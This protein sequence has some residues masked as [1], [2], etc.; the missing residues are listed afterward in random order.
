[1]ASQERSVAPLIKGKFW[2][3]GKVHDL[4][5][6]TAW[7]HRIGALLTNT[8]ILESAAFA[9]AIRPRQTTER[10][11]GHPL[12]IHWPM[13]LLMQFEE[14][15]EVHI[16]NVVCPLAE[17]DLILTTTNARAQ[18]SLAWEVEIT[19]HRPRF[20]FEETKPYIRRSMGPFA[21]TTAIRVRCPWPTISPT[22]RLRST[23][24]MAHS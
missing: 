18:F 7:C 10:P 12:V 1:M 23:S 16:G 21:S 2:S 19:G 5:D 17:C 11:D 3:L 9:S 13:S 24:A 15:V 14:R 6:W 8:S 4:T 22:M 20:D